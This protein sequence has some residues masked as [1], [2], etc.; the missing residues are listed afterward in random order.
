M[1]LSQSSVTFRKHPVFSHHGQS[2]VFEKRV[3]KFSRRC[4]SQLLRDSLCKRKNGS[5][6]LDL[7][8]TF[9]KGHSLLPVHP[10]G[11]GRSGATCFEASSRRHY[12]QGFFLLLLLATQHLPCGSF[13][14]RFPFG[15][16]H[17]VKTFPSFPGL[18]G[19]GNAV[20]IAGSLFTQIS[21][22]LSTG[23]QNMK[24]RPA[25]LVEKPALL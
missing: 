23:C 2:Q 19:S 10:A 22:V 9:L 7:E 13:A 25:V 18:C 20:R 21:H 5:V 6:E 12:C 24:I 14:K 3:C 4:L 15:R 16:S 11:A 8:S 17:A 1:C